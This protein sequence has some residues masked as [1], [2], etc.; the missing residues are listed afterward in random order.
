MYVFISSS[1][2]S[3]ASTRTWFLSTL[4]A[5]LQCNA[6]YVCVCVYRLLVQ[7][8]SHIIRYTFTQLHTHTHTHTAP[9][10]CAAAKHVPQHRTDCLP[11]DWV[12]VCSAVYCLVCIEWCVCMY[13][14]CIYP[15]IYLHHIIT[16]THTHIYIYR[17]R[18]VADLKSQMHLWNQNTS[19]NR[20][21][22]HNASTAADGTCSVVRGL[23]CA[24]CDC[25]V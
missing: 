18:L 1:S 20:P 19:H 15:H 6:W 22:G 11:A 16:H 3:S 9:A 12:S 21:I 14:V 13:V 10:A 25:V 5:T 24:V 8:Y 23:W 4:V 7:I 17:A 2:S